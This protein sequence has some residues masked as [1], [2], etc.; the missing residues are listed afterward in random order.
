MNNHFKTLFLIFFFY[1]KAWSFQTEWF[2]VRP[3]LLLTWWF[4]CRTWAWPWLRVLRLRGW[5]AADRAPTGGAFTGVRGAGH[6]WLGEFA[7]AVLRG[8]SL[9]LWG[10]FPLAL[11]RGSPLTR[12]VLWLRSFTQTWNVWSA[13]DLWAG[14]KGLVVLLYSKVYQY[15]C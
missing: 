1:T 3:C 7:L 4:A 8:S 2:T 12:R 9:T 5:Q 11:L 6:L 14:T 10:L 15:Y 13:R